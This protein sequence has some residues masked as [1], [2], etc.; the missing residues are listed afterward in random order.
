[1]SGDPSDR[2]K[3][4]APPVD[5]GRG[6]QIEPTPAPVEAPPTPR[7]DDSDAWAIS[8]EQ[9]ARRALIAG[10]FLIV[11]LAVW[12]FLAPS[13]SLYVISGSTTRIQTVL[14]DDRSWAPP[15]RFGG[16]SIRHDNSFIAR[17]F[18]GSYRPAPGTAIELEIVSA[19]AMIV[20]LIPEGFDDRV[21][22]SGT[23]VGTFIW[24]LGSD[25]ERIKAFDATVADKNDLAWGE[26]SIEQN[27]DCRQSQ[28][29]A[30]A[31]FGKAFG[32]A[33]P[34][35]PFPID[36]PTEIGRA[37]EASFMGDEFLG[38]DHQSVSGQIELYATSIACPIRRSLGTQGCPL[39]R[40][41]ANPMT[42]PAGA[43]LIPQ[44][45]LNPIQRFLNIFGADIAEKP[46]VTLGEVAIE[47]GLISFSVSVNAIDLI[48]APPAFGAEFERSYRLNAGLLQ[49]LAAEPAFQVLFSIILTLI[50]T[51]VLFS[52]EDDKRPKAK[53]ALVAVKRPENRLMRYNVKVARRK[54]SARP[55]EPRDDA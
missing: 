35:E 8:L 3:R 41:L 52:N 43:T 15:L 20:T 13:K 14:S 30:A 5:P 2:S 40:V 19:D 23:S 24:P 9:L 37:T 46:V 53:L 6:D 4:D 32:F 21:P 7:E 48:I 44:N 16:V 27:I 22:G 1:M 12:S 45:P 47:N 54:F 25:A 36:G 55:E 51:I 34:H 26:T 50:S 29:D 33:T 39:N 38:R 31:P 42:I 11:F 28:I 17:C 18:E 10:I 49:Q